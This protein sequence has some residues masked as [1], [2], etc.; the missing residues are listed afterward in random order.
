MSAAASHAATGGRLAI[1]AGGGAL[2][3]HVA[4][5][6]RARRVE[7]LEDVRQRVGRDARAVVAHEQAGLVCIGLGGDDRTRGLG[8]SDRI[9]GNAG[10]DVLRGGRGRD[11]L[12]GGLGRDKLFGGAGRDVLRGGPGRDLQVQ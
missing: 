7:R 9:C 8:G 5:A 2:P 4:E 12:F 11:R 6:V 3:H 10:R 1:I